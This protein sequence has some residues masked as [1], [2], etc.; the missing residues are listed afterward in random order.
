MCFTILR[1]CGIYRQK[2]AVSLIYIAS[3]QGVLLETKILSV[4]YM[5]KLA[6]LF[7]HNCVM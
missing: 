2:F 1:L 3:L 5:V 6:N 4:H 7:F